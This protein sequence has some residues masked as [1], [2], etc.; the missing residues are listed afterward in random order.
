M[1]QEHRFLFSRIASLQVTF[2]GR[3]VLKVFFEQK[4]FLDCVHTVNLPPGSGFGGEVSP[5]L[6]G[7][8]FARLNLMNLQKNKPKPLSTVDEDQLSIVMPGAHLK[9]S[10]LK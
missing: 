10:I 2:S 5:N 6:S 4:T 8:T 7:V 9:D 3:F 1:E